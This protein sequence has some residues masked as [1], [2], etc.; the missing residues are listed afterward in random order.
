MI[1]LLEILYTQAYLN[2]NI[3]QNNWPGNA[4]RILFNS[5]IASNKNIGLGIP[6]L[7]NGDL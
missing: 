6:G 3:D 2:N 7:Y 4:L 5:I 1:V